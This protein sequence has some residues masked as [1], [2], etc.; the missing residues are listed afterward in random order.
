MPAVQPVNFTMAG[1]VII[2]IAPEIVTG[3]RIP[4]SAAQ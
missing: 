4:A 2:R 1:D 3:R